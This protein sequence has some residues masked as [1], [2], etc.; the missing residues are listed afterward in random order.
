MHLADGFV[1]YGGAPFF[2]VYL[3]VIFMYVHVHIKLCVFIGA[4]FLILYLK[5][6]VHIDSGVCR[7]SLRHGV[8]EGHIYICI[9]I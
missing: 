5:L 2:M 3:K 7:R 1:L 6:Y 4:L 9:C 8:F